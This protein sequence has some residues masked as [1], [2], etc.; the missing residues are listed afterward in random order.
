VAL[1]SVSQM[2]IQTMLMLTLLHR[3]SQEKDS[4]DLSEQH[5]TFH[6]RNT[7]VQNI[8]QDNL[9]VYTQVI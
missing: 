7:S 8:I 1:P 6:S 3:N 4:C 9:M 5:S 2:H